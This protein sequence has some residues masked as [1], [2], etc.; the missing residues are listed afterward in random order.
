[1]KLKFF[2]LLSG[3]LITLSCGTSKELGT[4]S[5]LIQL[6]KVERKLIHSYT[7]DTTVLSVVF[8]QY[9]CLDKPYKDTVNHFTCDYLH[10]ITTFSSG[11]EKCAIDSRTVHTLLDT[12]AMIYYE[13]EDEN[14]PLWGLEANVSINE[15]PDFVELHQSNYNYTG[16]AH[17]NSF[18]GILIIDKKDGKELHLNDFFT[19]IDE[20]NKRVEPYFRKSMELST[21]EDL[22]EAGYWF[23]DGR[24]SVNDNFYF[25][26]DSIYFYYNAYEIAPYAAGPIEISVPVADIRSLLRRTIN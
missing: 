7:R 25:L 4:D 5:G 9:T 8:E 17:G 22:I 18:Y 12:F 19:D 13:D 16:G 23:P 2:Y 21:D 11:P 15:F 1:M 14:Y 10:T 3:L 24:F 26:N 6:N 20:V